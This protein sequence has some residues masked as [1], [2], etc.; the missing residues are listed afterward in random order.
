[1]G[2]QEEHAIDIH[3]DEFPLPP[4]QLAKL[5]DPK[6]PALL[7]EIGGLAGLERDLRTSIKNGLP[8]ASGAN[9]SLE[10]KRIEKYGKNILPPTPRDTFLE[11]VWGALQD[12]V[13]L[14]LIGAA[15]LSIVLGSI[16]ATSEDPAK[17]WI[18]GVAILFAVVI[19][20]G[21]TSGNDFQKQRQFAKLDAK[22]NDRVVKVVRGGEQAQ[23]PILDV[24]A[25]DIIMLDT[26]DIV[27]ADGIFIEGHGLKTD[28]SS[29]TGES[30]PVKKVTP[31]AG[32]GDSFM[33]SGS[34][35]IEGMGRMLVIAVGPNSFNGRLLL[36]LRVPDEDTPLQEKLEVLAGNI[37]KF[38]IIAAALLLLIGIPKYFIEAKINNDLGTKNFKHEVGSDIVKLV[39]NAITIVVVAVPEGLPLAV[40]IALAYGM[41]KMLEDNNL[42]RHL[43]ACE[44][45]GGATN[46]CS[47]KTGTLTQNVMTVVTGWFGGKRYGDITEKAGREMPQN[48]RDALCEGIAVNSSAFE[49]TNPKGKI[50]FVG[51]KTECALLKLSQMFGYDYHPIRTKYEP[52]FKLYPF[53]SARKS[54]STVVKLDNGA[55]RIYTKGASEIILGRCD[56]L[57]V[58]TGGPQA[59]VRELDPGLRKEL[60]DTI[61]DFA[62]DALRTICLG[63]AD[64]YEDRNWEDAPESGF[65]MIAIVGIRDPLRPEVPGA[66]ATCQRAGITV[67]MVTGDNIITAQNIAKACGILKSGGLCLEGPVFR[68]MPAAERA[69]LLPRLQVL[70]RSS[71]TD[72]QLLVGMLKEAGEVVAVTG[73]G[74]N[75]GPALK[76]AD[77]GFSMGI[78]GTEVAIAASDVVLLDDNFASIVK[79]ALWGRNIF[80]A[81][82][83]FIQFQLT[84]NVVAVAIAFV[85]TLSGSHGE[86]PLTAV[87][88]LWVNLIMDSLAALSLATE[89]PTPSLLERKPIGRDAPL[90]TRKMWRFIVVHSIYQLIVNFVLLYAG[91]KIFGHR[92]KLHSTEHYTLIFNTFVFMQLFNEINARRLEDELNAFSGMFSNRFFVA[93]LIAT[94]IVQAIFVEFGGEFTSTTGL[95]YWE[96]FVCILLGAIELPLGVLC[97]LVPVDNVEG[98]PP[99]SSEKF[100]TELE[101]VGHPIASSS[102]VTEPLVGPRTT[103]E[104]RAAAAEGKGSLARPVSRTLKRRWSLVRM[105]VRQIG[106]LNA[107]KAMKTYRTVHGIEM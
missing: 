48:M 87:Q 73:D 5:V 35:I 94:A 21:V 6:N 65:T 76:M 29:V 54:M 88:L 42:V 41:L 84:V 78:S 46:I 30:D 77:I 38:G 75:D 3:S 15:V 23:I 70:A 18:D 12:Q 103:Q 14:L 68:E 55:Y 8:S 34:Q 101:D 27:C 67:R 51:S 104:Y 80:D 72:K 97:R 40:T 19:V 17:G 31:G 71:P 74:T 39:I 10:Q 89:A 56:K 86:S 11:I 99:A 57:L 96:W 105:A 92:F 98:P 32:E 91:D 24:L 85:G 81:I 69:A 63:Y 47:D 1:M 45:M 66:V 2:T 52:Y 33:I 25:G 106:V 22:K 36:A 9:D 37:G 107:F 4:S 100:D 64:V 59:E 62:T 44:T 102:N 58:N 79:A 82:R 49:A 43:A 50:D 20:V 26:G 60:L 7:K 13:L 83:K 93:I 61:T 28:E 90:I 95:I 16:P 53:S